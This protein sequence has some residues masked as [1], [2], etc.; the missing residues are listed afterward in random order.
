MRLVR[1]GDGK[2]LWAGTV[3]SRYDQIFTLEDSLAQQIASNLTVRLSAEERRSL[4]FRRALNPQA[5]ELYLKGRFE[6]GKRSQAGFEKAAEYFQQAIDADPTYARAY[7]GLAD[8]YLLLGGY[9]RHP[10]ME[11]LPKAK[12]L[13]SRALE[14]DPTLAGGAH[15]PGP[16]CSEP[17]LGLGLAGGGK[18]LS[19][20]DFPGSELC[21]RAPLVC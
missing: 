20:G 4:G 2:A 9:S 8:S 3:E 12:A 11:T 6:W 5:H 18:S 14:L 17:G 13:A 10:Q 15:H 7:A 21:Y 1:P 19:Q 16:G